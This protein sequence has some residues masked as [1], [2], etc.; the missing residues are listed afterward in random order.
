[1]NNDV[2]NE[3]DSQESKDPADKDAELSSDI[4]IR[5]MRYTDSEE[6]IEIIGLAMNKEEAR[7]AKETI[8]FHY[9]CE[10]NNQDD[11]RNYLLATLNNQPIGITGLH[12]YIWGPEDI[13]WLGWFAVR[14]EYQRMGIG[15]K[16]MEETCEIARSRG[17]RKIFIETYSNDDFEKGREFY[18]KFGFV[19]TGSIDGY[20]KPDTD[21]VVYSRDLNGF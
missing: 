12:R 19:Q 16:M 10:Q 21:M 6:V 14:P 13:T 2:D 17:F 7:W 8:D 1:M 4:R 9:F 3:Y 18:E 5:E 20:L 15:K 11:G